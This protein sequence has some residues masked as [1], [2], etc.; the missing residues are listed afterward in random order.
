MLPRPERRRSRALVRARW[1]PAAGRSAY[2]KRNLVHG[3]FAAVLVVGVLIGARFP[4]TVRGDADSPELRVGSLSFPGLAGSVPVAAVTRLDAGAFPLVARASALEAGTAGTSNAQVATSVFGRTTLGSAGANA[5]GVPGGAPTPIAAANS[6]SNEGGAGARN[7]EQLSLYYRHQVQ[8]GDTVGSIAAKYG[9]DAKY[10]LWNNIDI[11]SDEQLLPVGITLQVPSVE[12]ILHS[13]RVDETLTD[14]ATQYD[15]KAPEII[16]FPANGLANPNMLREGSIILVPGGRVVPKPAPSLRPVAPPRAPSAESTPEPAA[17]PGAASAAGGTPGAAPPAATPPR[18]AAVPRASATPA[19][20]T[21]RAA[22]AGQPAFIWPVVN[23]I[24]SYFGPSH[25]LGIDINAPYVPVLASAAGQ[26]VF[27]GGDPCCSYGYN[28]VIR[29]DGGF[30]T[31][32]AHLSKFAVSLGQ[33]VEQGQS[34]GTSGS[35]GR[36]T[37][38]H[39]HFEL[40][41]NGVIQNPMLYMP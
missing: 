21:N 36:S 25:P 8:E 11:I 33:W 17:T 23:V 15:A 41:K 29:H 32:Y 14:I 27:A 7:Q 9:I 3:A 37:G 39:V 6:G 12:G 2:L 31:R 4:V 22:A 34:L 5:G 30:E 19:A 18:S 24:T 40:T 26:V 10:I 1:H 16:A 38:A 13:V 28:V 20:A 35:T